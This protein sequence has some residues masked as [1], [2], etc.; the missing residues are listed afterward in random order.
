MAIFDQFY[1]KIKDLRSMTSY[2]VIL[3][4]MLMLA[5]CAP[6]NEGFL[7][8]GIGPDLAISKKSAAAAR[9]IQHDYFDYLCQEAGLNYAATSTNKQHCLAAKTGK[10]LWSPIVK[11]GLNDIDRRCDGYLAWL[12]DRRRSKDPTL[13]QITAISNASQDFIRFT[14]I[15]PTKS[16]SIVSRAFEL[17]TDSI[18]NYHSRLLLEVENSTVTA[19]VFRERQKF[20]IDNRDVI[21]EANNKPDAEHY[22]RRY[23]QICMPFSIEAA[24]NSNAKLAALG[25]DDIEDRS[26]HTGKALRESIPDSGGDEVTIIT[27]PTPDAD[28]LTKSIRLSDFE[29]DTLGASLDKRV[30][31]QTALCVT[32]TSGIFAEKTRKA[33]QMATEGYNDAKSGT[34]ADIKPANDVIDTPVEFE[35]FIKENLCSAHTNGYKNAYEKMFFFATDK[36]VQA[37]ERLL[38]CYSNLHGNQYEKH[39]TLLTQ[40]KLDANS[41]AL[42]KTVRESILKVT[43]LSGKIENEVS[44]EFTSLFNTAGLSTCGN[45]QFQDAL[46]GN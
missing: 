38:N 23:L 22:L 29:K 5:S 11:Q 40:E 8:Y 34:Q 24:I 21:S 1:L 20:R 2:C 30:A 36:I 12:D 45:F 39:A 42:I 13:N 43:G 26:L 9:E 16:I 35:F 41:R 37:H 17:I 44:E 27:P 4:A 18:N 33:I 28:F 32:P 3:F 6:V 19:I 31:L 25:I 7:R 15:D 10:N 46:K 14:D